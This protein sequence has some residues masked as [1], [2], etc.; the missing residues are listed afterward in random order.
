[1]NV[2]PKENRIELQKDGE[3]EIALTRWGPDYDDPTTYLNLLLENNAYNYGGYA[4]PDFN[5]TMQAA[6][7]APTL[8]QRWEL[9]K[10]AEA[11]LLETAPVIPVFQTGTA[12]LLNPKVTGLR[13][14]AVGVTYIYKSLEIME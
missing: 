13:T 5:A 4:D 8:E 2:Q 10:D 1:L 9:L 11:I 3:F 14:Q 12:V 7:D 6:A